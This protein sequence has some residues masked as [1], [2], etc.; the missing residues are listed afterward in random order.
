MPYLITSLWS[1]NWWLVLKIL[2]ISFFNHLEL[3]FCCIFRK[4]P[5]I[6]WMIPWPWL[7]NLVTIWGGTYAG[8]DAGQWI[9]LV[10][11]PCLVP[12]DLLTA[13]EYE[14]MS[15]WMSSLLIIF[16]ISFNIHDHFHLDFFNYLLIVPLIKLDIYC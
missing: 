6:Y 4:C 9:F 5:N 7:R 2:S 16:L 1:V 8:S 10:L 12:C 3:V 11:I 13:A 14:R 15:Y